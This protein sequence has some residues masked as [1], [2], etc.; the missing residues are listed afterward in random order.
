MFLLK[1][2]IIGVLPPSTGWVMVSEIS[3]AALIGMGAAHKVS[4][5]CGVQARFA[6]ATWNHQVCLPVLRLHG[7]LV[8]R[9]NGSS[10]DSCE[11]PSP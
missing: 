1:A 11:G 10:G 2:V 9:I 8:Q 3:L 6:D 5:R 7:E 4:G